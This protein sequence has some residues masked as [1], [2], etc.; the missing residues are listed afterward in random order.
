[1][2]KTIFILF[3]LIFSIAAWA[4]NSPITGNIPTD[5]VLILSSDVAQMVGLAQGY[6]AGTMWIYRRNLKT[7]AVL[8]STGCIFVQVSQNIL[9]INDPDIDHDPDGYCNSRQG[10]NIRLNAEKPHEDKGHQHPN[11]Q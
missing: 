9:H 1:M 8:F 4:N 2:K 7:L 10:Y 3:A 11:W 6:L 5:S